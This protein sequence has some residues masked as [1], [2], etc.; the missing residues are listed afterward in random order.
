M[1]FEYPHIDGSWSLVYISCAEGSVMISLI[2]KYILPKEIDFFDLLYRQSRLIENM[3]NNLNSCFLEGD[4]NSSQK[5]MSLVEESKKMRKDSMN[6][7]F[8]TFITPIDREAIYRVINELDWIAISI[9]HFMIETQTYHIKELREYRLLLNIISDMSQNISKS[10]KALDKNKIQEI[11]GLCDTIRS[12]YN[13]AV[14]F[15]I[16]YMS[17][18]SKSQDIQKLFLYKEILF[19]MRDISKR[20]LVTASYIED[21]VAKML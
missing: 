21:I 13:Q 18:L 10:L 9:Y 2:K 8:A 4:T 5:T 14:S 7:L 11:V 6:Q 3:T 19:Q 20:L 12:Q 17:D 16:D 15:Y 1:V